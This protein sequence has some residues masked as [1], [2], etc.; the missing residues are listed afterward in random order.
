MSGIDLLK[1]HDP[2]EPCTLLLSG[3][4]LFSGLSF[5]WKYPR[6]S[7]S[8]SAWS[9]PVAEILWRLENR[10]ILHIHSNHF[11]SEETHYFTCPFFIQSICTFWHCIT[12]IKPTTTDKK[13]ITY[14]TWWILLFVVVLFSIKSASILAVT[15][16]LNWLWS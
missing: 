8:S 14:F 13:Y 15:F 11:K 10:E 5:E 2:L 12:A 6:V 7:P 16:F 1:F 3:I 4:C 9:E